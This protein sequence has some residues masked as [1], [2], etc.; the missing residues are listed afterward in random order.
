MGD[1]GSYFL[2]FTLA[3][4]SLL[5]LNLNSSE[6]A[7]TYFNQKIFY[8]IILNLIYPIL[9]MCS[10]II[11]RINK[12][13]SIFFPDRSHIHHKLLDFGL[14]TKRIVLEITL[15]SIWMTSISYCLID[16]VNRWQFFIV[17][18]LIYF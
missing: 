17:F 10:V 3:S 9:D 13:R 7:F 5:I 4:L 16:I 15:L 18:T 1:S 6:I 12:R 14:S 11:Q 2:G 8:A